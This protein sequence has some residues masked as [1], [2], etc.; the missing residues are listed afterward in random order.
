MSVELPPVVPLTRVGGAVPV[1][2]VGGMVGD[3]MP[4]ARLLFFFGLGMIVLFDQH[5]LLRMLVPLLSRSCAHVG[6]CWRI[7]RFKWG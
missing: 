5:V 7:G 1:K 3:A 2:S 6:I 4:L